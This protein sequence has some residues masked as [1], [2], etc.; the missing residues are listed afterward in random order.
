ME[1]LN[2]TKIALFINK[3][4]L[5]CP[6]IVYYLVYFIMTQML[7]WVIKISLSQIKEFF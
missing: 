4:S 3:Y 5:F 2:R 7:V 1:I 6:C